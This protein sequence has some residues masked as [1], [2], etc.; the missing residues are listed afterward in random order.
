[1]APCHLTTRTKRL[2][3]KDKTPPKQIHIPYDAITSAF[4]DTKKV[5]PGSSYGG[6]QRAVD[7]RTA[8]KVYQAQGS[9]PDDSIQRSG[10]EDF[11][12]SQASSWTTRRYFIAS[13]HRWRRRQI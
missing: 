3:F 10:F 2:V 7:L 4:A 5:Q 9:L 13:W 11:R 1:M 12:V 6:Q 8:R